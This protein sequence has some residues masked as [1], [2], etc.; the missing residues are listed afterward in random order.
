M[1]WYEISFMHRTNGTPNGPRLA[2]A[3]RQLLG[4]DVS[5]LNVEQV[6]KAG[7][8][9]VA[10]VRVASYMA[11]CRLCPWKYRYSRRSEAERFAAMHEEQ[12]H[13]ADTGGQDSQPD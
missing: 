2:A 8:E 4:S 3:L 9:N 1:S 10:V 12:K 5:D 6:E 7:R 11:V 13:A